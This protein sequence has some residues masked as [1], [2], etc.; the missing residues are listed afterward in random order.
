LFLT[1]A[2]DC[3]GCVAFAAGDSTNVSPPVYTAPPVLVSAQRLTRQETLDRAGSFS[4]VIYSSS[5]AGGI[6][7]AA[8]A[9]AEAVGVT[10]RETGGLG[11]YSSVSLRGS[12]PSQV[13]IYLD[14]VPLSSLETGD[15]NL[16]DIPLGSLDRIEVYRGAAP[17]VMGGA[18][19]GG[20][21]HLVS[22]E[23]AGRP[24]LRLAAGSYDTRVLDA[25]G[26]RALA[27]WVVHARLRYLKSR[28]DWEFPF[29]NR[30]PYNTADDTMARRVNN[31]LSGGGGMVTARGRVGGWGLRVAELLDV[32]EQGIPGRDL[33]AGS[34]RGSTLTHQLRAVVSPPAPRDGKLRA[35]EV[36]HRL[37]QQRFEDRLGE[38]GLGRTERR[39][40]VHAVGASAIGALRPSGE[41][42]WRIEAYWGQ[43]KSAFDYPEEEDGPPQTRITGAAALQP[44]W[45]GLNRRLLVQ[46][47]L[48]LE[49]HHDRF[50]GTPPFGNYDLPDGPI[51]TGTTWAPTAQLGVRYA[52]STHL[53][54]KCNAGRYARVPTLLERFGHRGTVIGNPDLEPESGINR[55]VGFVWSRSDSDRRLMASVFY[56]T[57][58]D[59]IVFVRN[60]QLTSRA[61]NV[62]SATIRGVEVDASPGR[63]GPLRPS[64]RYTGL[65]TEDTGDDAT[66][67]GQPLP[68]RPGY[69]LDAQIDL[70]AR[71]VEF[72]Y[73]FVALGDNTLERH[74]RTAIPSR[75]LHNLHAAWSVAGVTAALRL[76]NVANDDSLFD[77]YGWPL[78]GRQ[79]S[80]SLQ[81][82]G[83]HAL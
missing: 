56:N 58:E 64:L 50:H 80:L 54:L 10:V 6:E 45:S 35:I 47:G 4:S 52:L 55:D 32:R 8:S 65:D 42:A 7:T 81:T 11:G 12:T 24:W 71:G 37:D 13:P 3:F 68:G 69:E 31:D 41:D 20:A 77:L 17:L 83:S 36:F 39:D 19:L 2:L 49:V 25:G 18:S 53:A 1:I 57:S 66:F 60:S 29:D 74:G 14:G 75:S 22:A 82:R 21:I 38:L 62:G 61:T 15:V 78:P 26:G 76:D 43:L 28:G 73:E 44:S 51:E 33:Q 48:R 16:A 27:D 30:T 67:R 9:L 59:L 5:W 63:I 46:P 72:G 34:A 40:R 79:W 23:G 70:V